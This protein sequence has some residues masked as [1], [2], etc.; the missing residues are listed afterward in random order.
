MSETASIPPFVNKTMKFLLRSPLHGMVSKTVVLINFTGRN[1]GKAFATPVSYTQTGNQIHIFT[2]AAW[3]KN[4]H[5]DKPVT[6][7]LR[8]TEVQ[9]YPEVI[10]EDKQ[11]IASELAAHLRSVPSD[12]PYYKVTFDHLGNPKS[13]EVQRAVQTVVMIHIHLI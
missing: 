9:G 4:L 7:H 11:A 3:W 1:S 5:S 6:L 12:A 10:V 13:E 8:G 2:H